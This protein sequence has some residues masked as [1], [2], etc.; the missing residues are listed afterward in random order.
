MNRKKRIH[1]Q[2]VRAAVIAEPVVVEVKK[3]PKP[4]T[5]KAK[6]EPKGE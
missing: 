2:E 6:V 5:V 3:T 1:R 4:K